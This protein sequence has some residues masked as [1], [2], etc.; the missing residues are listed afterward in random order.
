MRKINKKIF[1]VILIVIFV[2]SPL[3]IDLLSLSGNLA[4]GEEQMLGD[5]HITENT[6]WNNNT[7]LSWYENIYVEEGVTLTIEKGS[8]LYFRRLIV[9][10]NVIA[11]GTLEEKIKLT[12]I[13]PV[14][15]EGGIYDPHCFVSPSASIEFSGPGNYV[16]DPESVFEFVEFSQM[17]GYYNYDT[18]NCPGMV[19]N[20]SLRNLFIPTAYASPVE[21]FA[22]AVDFFSGKVKMKNCD[23]KNNAYSDIKVEIE[24]NDEWGGQ[25][26]LQ[27]ENS[28]FENNSQA[29][30]LMSKVTKPDVYDELFENCFNECKNNYPDGYMYWEVCTN[31]CNSIAENDPSVHDKTKVILKNNWYGDSTG[32]KTEENPDALG[33][34]I[35]G[36]YFLES[37]SAEKNIN[38]VE[39][40][41]SNVLFLPGIKAS[42]LYKNSNSGKDRLWPPNYFGDDVAE[43]A[44]DENGDS[45]EDVYAEGIIEELPFTGENIY[46]S[47]AEKLADLKEKRNINDYL[48]LAYDWRKNVADV[49]VMQQIE[50][51][52]MTSQNR[53][54]T[55][56]AHSNGGLLAKNIMQKLEEIGMEEVV[57]KII[58]VGSP[59][60]GT[61]MSIFSLLY[62]YDEE[63]A[64][65]SLMSRSEARKL[66][67]NMPGA[68]G[69]LPSEEYFNR[70]KEPLI[71]FSAVD[72]S[73]ETP[74]KIFKESYGE[75]I[76]KGEFEKFQ[77]FL[78]GKIDGREKPAEE[79]IEKENILRENLLEEAVSI[80]ESLDEWEPP[81]NVQ[82]IQIAGWG[83]DTIS[84][85]K[86]SQK[87]KVICSPVSGKL[88][89]CTGAGEYEPIYEPSW[90]VDGDEVV[91]VPSA[92]MMPE[93]EN[94]VEKYWVDLWSYDDILTNKRNHGDILE[95][96]DLQEFISNIIE[97][98]DYSSSLPEYIHTSRPEDYDNAKPRIR[99]SLHSPLDVHLYDENGNHTGPKEITDENGNWKTIFEESIPNSYYW[100][101]GE[102]KYVG[103]SEG[104]KISIEMKGYDDGAYSLKL[105]EVALSQT[106][107]EVVSHTAFANLPVS[108]DTSVALEVPEAGLA[109]LSDLKADFDGDEEIDY[110]VAPVP[111]GEATLNTDEISPEIVI[112]SPENKTYPGNLNLEI[113]FSVSDNISVPENIATEI[114]L[115]NEKISLKMIDLSKLIPGDHKFKISAVDEAD[116]ESEKEIEFS[117]G[118]NIAIFQSNVEKYYQAGLIKKKAEKNKLLAESKLIQN[119]IKLLQMIRTN[120]FLKKKTKNLLIMLIEREIDRQID[121]MI[122]RVEKDKKNYDLVIKNIII[123]DLRWIKNN[124]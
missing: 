108:K 74:Y 101:F 40:G 85:V 90:T 66:V 98:K 22:P 12:G 67:E 65:G 115:D 28:N 87:E 61:P 118:M 11:Q 120:P 72:S 58:F 63:L 111:N 95:V 42:Y 102:R 86:Y 110:A 93:K 78:T 14:F 13:Q 91:T 44:L 34:K 37:W 59:Q 19:M 24:Y 43:L 17:G 52:V 4:R 27:I 117:I 10:G 46:K 23:F 39:G 36:D 45:L 32:P 60:M 8:Q 106:G 83:L 76:G 18:D 30:A 33:E 112:I 105:E 1:T 20:N 9:W 68:Y 55:I 48:L 62:G 57:D 79:D 64:L 5:W 123:E 100:Q 94:G 92:L 29:T 103:F 109:D 69:L 31:Q 77:N 53:K 71:D 49:E 38:T 25:S 70:L 26:Y 96:S 124:L 3:R 56:I 80:H 73:L 7:D 16:D 21:K 97:N 50:N 84:G 113:N 2:I 81:E 99:M 6:I 51:L 122:R 54:I 119:E 116:N 121:F 35:S 41:G 107:E 104:E 88:P 89:S 75:N 15:G 114:Y 47:L 82:V